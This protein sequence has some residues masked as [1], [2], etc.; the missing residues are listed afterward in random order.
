MSYDLMVFR[1]DIAPRTRDEFMNWFDEQVKWAEDHSYNDPAVTSGNLRNWFMEMIETFPA[2]NGPYAD[3]DIDDDSVTDYC[4]GTNVIY[5]AF[6]WSVAEKAYNVMKEAAQKHQ[7]GFYDVSANN[8]DILFPDSNG[9]NLP[10]DNAAGLS[11]IQQIKNSAAPGQ[12]N[13]S[14]REILYSKII[15][16]ILE[17]STFENQTKTEKKRSW[18]QRLFG[19]K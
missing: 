3:E 14:V 8:G 5:A 7:V 6:A 19:L 17:Q 18:W 10:I 13:A 11:S 2:M 9:K 1:P 4:I 16:Q 15:P 12:E